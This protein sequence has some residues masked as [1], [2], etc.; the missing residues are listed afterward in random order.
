MYGVV[1]M[2]VG[3]FVKSLFKVIG[4]HNKGVQGGLTMCIA[5]MECASS[6]GGEALM[7]AF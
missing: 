1:G 3:L 7:V 5:K 4:E 2:V 6:C